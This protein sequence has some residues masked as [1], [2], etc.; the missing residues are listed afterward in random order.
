[1][2]KLNESMKYIDYSFSESFIF[3]LPHK[4]PRSE[5]WLFREKTRIL[6][7]EVGLEYLKRNENCYVTHWLSVAMY[8]IRRSCETWEVSASKRRSHWNDCLIHDK[9]FIV[10][11]EVAGFLHIVIS[12]NLNYFRL[13]ICDLLWVMLF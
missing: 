7:Q 3:P 1:M 2:W 6:T 8:P 13:R 5:H 9:V 4:S 10:M 11:T 12:L